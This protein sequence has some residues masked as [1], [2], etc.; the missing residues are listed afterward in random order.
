MPERNKRF[1]KE[2]VIESFE[3]EFSFKVI[4]FKRAFALFF[5]LAIVITGYIISFYLLI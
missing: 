2:I 5:S 1:T 3:E 4:Y